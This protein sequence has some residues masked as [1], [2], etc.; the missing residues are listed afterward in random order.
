MRRHGEL[1]F[2]KSRD[3][4]VLSQTAQFGYGSGVLRIQ[5]KTYG[6][7]RSAPLNSLQLR[8]GLRSG[9]HSESPSR[10]MLLDGVC[11]PPVSRSLAMFPIFSSSFQY[12]FIFIEFI[13]CPT[14]VKLFCDNHFSETVLR[15]LSF[16]TRLSGTLYASDLGGRTT[17]CLVVTFWH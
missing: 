1:P 11:A 2:K 4:R 5:Q 8:L 10:H 15:V 7:D 6:A 13:F 14:I 17:R 16:S 3:R 12:F 9:H